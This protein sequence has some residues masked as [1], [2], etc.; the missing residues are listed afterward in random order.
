MS[1]TLPSAPCVRPVV[2]PGPGAG[3]SGTAM[4]VED[5]AQVVQARARFVDFL[6]A[7]ARGPLAAAA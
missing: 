6:L 7:P 1:D 5:Y 3:L 2:P 4:S